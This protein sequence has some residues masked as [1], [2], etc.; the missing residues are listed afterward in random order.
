MWS[1]FIRTQLNLPLQNS[2]PHKYQYTLGLL[3]GFQVFRS[4][5]K[6]KWRTAVSKNKD[7]FEGAGRA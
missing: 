3:F 4:E 7:V 6:E 5:G 1:T 2:A